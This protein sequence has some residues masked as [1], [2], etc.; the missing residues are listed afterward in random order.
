M[1][2]MIRISVMA[3]AF[4]MLASDGLFAQKFPGLDKSPADIAYLRSGD[5]KAVA[6]VVYS[7]PQK[8]G[9]EVMGGLIPE[10][11]VW[12]T[13]A[14]EA[15][16]ITF[17]QDVKFGGKEVKA[18]TYSLFTIAGEEEWTVIL[19]TDLNQWGAYSYQDGHDLLRVK[20][21]PKQTADEIEAFTITFDKTEGGSN[22]ILA[23]DRVMVPVLVSW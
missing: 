21:S 10:G 5:R 6:K 7:R 13:G 14:N 8:K 19:N 4:F 9:R 23:W 22:L 16:E 2:S 1:Q 17:F 15:T 3:L 20:A 11:K 18:G 12:R